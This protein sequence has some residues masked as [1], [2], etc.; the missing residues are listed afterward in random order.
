MPTDE[1]ISDPVKWSALMDELD[2]QDNFQ[3]EVA[4]VVADLAKKHDRL[5]EQVDLALRNIARAL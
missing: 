1:E 4:R 3:M 5:R 2:K